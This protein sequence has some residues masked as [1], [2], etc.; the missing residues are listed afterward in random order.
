MKTRK[1]ISQTRAMKNY[2]PKEK[3]VDQ[4]AEARKQALAQLASIR[5]MVKALEK[6]EKKG[7]QGKDEC[8]TELEAAEQTIH[9]DALSVE[10]KNSWHSVGDNTQGDTEYRILLCTGGPA[11]QIIGELNQFNEPETAEI[12]YQ[13]W[14]TPWENLTGL[15]Q[16]DVDCL[17]RYARCF[18]FGE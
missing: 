5:E 4:N 9:E 18:Y 3:P 15:E 1:P 10:V 16:K 8:G 13:D 12:Q 11:V 14:F 2:L 6:A 17:L 7:S